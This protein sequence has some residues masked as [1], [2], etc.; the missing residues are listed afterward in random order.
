[1]ATINR[2]E[3]LNNKFRALE[4][5][6]NQIAYPDNEFNKMMSL[7]LSNLN[8]L[9]LIRTRY[10]ESRLMLKETSEHDRKFRTENPE[11][12]SFPAHPN[13]NYA[14]AA[15]RVDVES[16]FIF[17]LTL[18]NKMILLLDLYLPD[19]KKMD[20]KGNNQ[21][22]SIAKFYKWL[23]VDNLSGLASK[24]KERIFTEIKWLYAVLRFYRN[25]FIEHVDK[26]Y[27]QGMG[28]DSMTIE[29]FKL[30]AF[31][32]KTGTAEYNEE[33]LKFKETLLQR[34]VEL[35][36]E[37][38]PRHYAQLMFNSITWIPDDILD[39]ALIIIEKNGVETPTPIELISHI[40]QFSSRIFDFMLEEI[41][42]SSLEQY[43]KTP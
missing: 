16:M 27:Q 32:W 23:C 34:G 29:K 21:Y 5:E 13:E 39:N 18:V 37:H 41:S 19:E 9:E 20:R 6:L 12:R 35:P 14:H 30:H 4:K 11:A 17:G 26:G 3:D 42:N 1:M 38:N 43:R 25:E 8:S 10:E 15:I 33:I 36:P 7:V 31:S 28:W 40:N 22:A 24:L 2:L